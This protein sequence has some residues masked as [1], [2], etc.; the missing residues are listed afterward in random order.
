MKMECHKSTPWIQYGNDSNPIMVIL[1]CP[2]RAEYEKQC[3]AVGQ[4]GKNIERLL[5]I[6]K[7]NMSLKRVSRFFVKD[8]MEIVNASRVAHFVGA[9]KDREDQA[10]GK[11]KK[12]EVKKN[13]EF[14]EGRLSRTRITHV[15]CFGAGAK[16]AIELVRK[17][18]HGKKKLSK[19]VVIQCCHLSDQGIASPKRGYQWRSS[20]RDA[21]LKE[22][23]DFI[24]SKWEKNGISEFHAAREV[25]MKLP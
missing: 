19:R 7:E 3:P 5:E 13:V 9:R 2:G 17:S 4:T 6:L 10:P 25:R 18:D 22:V 14:V 11:W 16:L 12:S 8:R 20:G 23:A 21:R 1:N 15:L 24:A